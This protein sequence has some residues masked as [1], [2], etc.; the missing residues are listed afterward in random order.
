MCE[1]SHLAVRSV[2]HLRHTAPVPEWKGVRECVWK[3][4]CEW[5]GV[6]VHVVEGCVC[7]RT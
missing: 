3:G 4:V 7:A 6:C 1:G 2:R 5:K